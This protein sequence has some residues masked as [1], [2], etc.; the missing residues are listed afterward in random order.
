[1][2]ELISNIQ[3][4]VK[5]YKA[6][7]ASFL[8]KTNETLSHDDL[9]DRTAVIMNKIEVCKPRNY[10]DILKTTPQKCDITIAKCKSQKLEEDIQIASQSSKILHDY[11]Q[12]PASIVS[13]NNSKL[14]SL[15]Y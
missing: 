15:Y 13:Q 3:H 2:G 11:Q 4:E 7:A 1:M 5:S 12:H 14:W 10:T 6:C 8:N 9:N